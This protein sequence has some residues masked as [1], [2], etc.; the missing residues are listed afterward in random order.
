MPAG[1]GGP[2]Q[3]NLERNLR[4]FLNDIGFLH[5]PALLSAQEWGQQQFCDGAASHPK[6]DAKWGRRWLLMPALH[7]LEE[8]GLCTSDILEGYT[9]SLP[10]C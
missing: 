9:G 10:S 2:E 4:V 1:S 6:L 5:G 7:V 3:L 8:P